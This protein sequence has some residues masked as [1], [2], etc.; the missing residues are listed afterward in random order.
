MGHCLQRRSGHCASPRRCRGEV[1]Q[2]GV[3][4]ATENAGA[5]V[6]SGVDDLLSNF[7]Q[8]VPIGLIALLEKEVDSGQT[9]DIGLLS[10]YITDLFNDS[11]SGVVDESTSYIADWLTA[12][13]GYEIDPILASL[14]AQASTVAA[15]PAPGQAS[16]LD[17]S[18]GELARPAL[19][20][21]QDLQAFG[22]WGPIVAAEKLVEFVPG[23]GITPYLIGLGGDI[24]GNIVD[25]NYLYDPIGVPDASA[26]LLDTLG[27]TWSSDESTLLQTAQT[28]QPAS[29]SLTS[30]ATADGCSLQAGV[31]TC[32]VGIVIG[33]SGTVTNASGSPLSGATVQITASDGA[34]TSASVT[35]NGSG[36]FT[37]GVL[38]PQNDGEQI[39]ITASAGGTAVATVPVQVGPGPVEDVELSGPGSL[40][41]G[42]NAPIS[43]LVT[44]GYGNPVPEAPINLSAS[45]GSVT[46]EATV[47]DASGTFE[48]TVTT[49]ATGPFI[50]VV[51]VSPDSL[52]S[53]KLTIAVEPA[54]SP[55][56]VHLDAPSVAGLTASLAGTDSPGSN[57]F[58]ITE[59]TW[60]WG[61]GT[62]TTGWFP[63]SHTYAAGGTYTITVTATDSDGQTGTASTTVT[64]NAPSSNASPLNI[65][66]TMLPTAE[67]NTPYAA[68][69]EVA[70]GTPPY[71]FAWSGSL[72]PGLYFWSPQTL[73]GTPT[74]GGVYSFKETVSDSSLPQQ[75]VTET[76]TAVVQPTTNLTITTPSVP[77][78]TVGTPYTA[79][80]DAVG[81]DPPYTW[82]SVAG[83]EPPSGLTL[84]ANGVLSGTPSD[85]GYVSFSAMVTDHD[86]TVAYGGFTMTVSTPTA[87]GSGAL[88]EQIAP[89]SA[90]GQLM[91]ISCV[92]DAQ[93]TDCFA[94][95]P[96][97]SGEGQILHS[98]DGGATWTSETAPAGVESSNGVLWGLDC[99]SATVCYAGDETQ[100]IKTTDGQN[101]ALVPLPAEYAYTQR[102]S[103]PSTTDC[104]MV[105]GYPFIN[106]QSTAVMQ[107]TDGGSTWTTTTT[108][109]FSES[110]I[111]CPTTAVCWVAG[112]TEHG[113]EDGGV[114]QTTDG[115]GSWSV[116]QSFPGALML[117]GITCTSDV[118]CWVTGTPSGPTRDAPFVAYTT[119]GTTWNTVGTPESGYIGGAVTGG[120]SCAS[121]LECLLFNSSAQD[122][123]GTTSG[124]ASPWTVYPTSGQ[125]EGVS[126]VPS[127]ECWLVSDSGAIFATSL[128]GS[129]TPASGATQL[130]ITSSPVAT[131]PTDSPTAG[132]ITITEE[133]SLG[134]PIDA[135]PGGTTVSLASSSSTA[136]F[137]AT[138]GGA[139]SAWT[140]IPAG[141]SSVTVFYGDAAAGPATITASSGG[142]AS[143]TQVETVL[144]PQVITIT[145]NPPARAEVG[146]TYT[147]TATG[148]PSGGSVTFSADSGSTPGACTVSDAGVVVFAAVGSCIIDAN[149]GG[150]NGYAPAQ[151][152][153]QAITVSPGPP[154]ITWTPPTPIVY[155][156]GLSSGQLDATTSVPG[157]LI[158]SPFV[159]TILTAGPQRLNVTFIPTNLSEYAPATSTVTLQVVP[160]PT[161]VDVEASPNPAT[162]GGAVAFVASGLPLD[163]TGSVSFGASGS[164]LCAATVA[165][166]SASCSA[167]D[168]MAG[169]HQVTAT[170]S[171]DANYQGSSQ[172]VN[173]VVAQAPTAVVASSSPSST[174]FGNA[175][176]LSATGLPADATGS[177]A[178][179]AAGATLCSADVAAGAAACPTATLPVA[180]YAVT[181]SYS[182]DNDFLGSTATTSFT[183]TSAPAAPVGTVTPTTPSA[184]S[185]KPSPSTTSKLSAT[186]EAQYVRLA[187]RTA[188]VRLTCNG[189][190]GQRCKIV[191]KL[192]AIEELTRG[193]VIAAVARIAR[194]SETSRRLLL[195]RTALTLMAKESRTVSF[196]LDKT[197]RQLL[198]RLGTLK[199]TLTVSQVR[200]GRQVAWT[201][202][203]TLRAKPAKRR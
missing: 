73:S 185:G 121:A 58:A 12:L 102:I 116:A 164:A 171:G 46:P 113:T 174:S 35:T 83:T 194:R 118:Q 85:A 98:T 50:D 40:A 167:T 64:V 129:L 54:A 97:V 38:L 55:P 107:T 62:T 100:L 177:V 7:V 52:V 11:F 91:A 95:G 92:P 147:A 63:Q 67:V 1:D 172:T 157:V 61:D 65:T 117:N 70:G 41:G 39:T 176:K 108:P 29:L 152:A 9:L 166:G 190:A 135:P 154:A 140:T 145:S 123:Y 51:A 93:Q 42:S 45:S 160:A 31:P 89:G 114:L 59:L 141:A 143:A 22:D 15:S 162:Y 189:S 179:T 139:P 28:T 82:A 156:T 142:L 69:I 168:I 150:G 2:I 6:E 124:G 151:Q 57:G 19:W 193:K 186:I 125:S 195:A 76:I 68:S 199:V 103:C 201:K 86:G 120:V 137:S 17:L 43:G 104:Y 146:G 178:F 34:P 56:V 183:I 191:A 203:L 136:A 144:D 80:L 155:G 47:A 99:P 88:V 132:P 128:D 78:A 122:A 169:S 33:V 87:G 149:Q 188:S 74:E 75:T 119:D 110:G 187:G 161:T 53:G 36:A 44:D 115:G 112:Q 79:T 60:Q 26:G 3:A 30:D 16:A 134:D 163:A 200:S 94:V 173:I 202:A 84:S 81:G 181:A 148:G 126:C 138:S 197:G 66:N 14:V 170:Y 109:N 21:Y 101:W 48:A 96:G 23:I 196:A 8:N 180:S 153:Q 131:P 32:E 90:V 72:P 10:D 25:Q 49:P 24:G 37:G 175:V 27:A 192:T 77:N 184:S 182:G 127:G 13:N 4:F 198:A 5:L 71:T 105:A 133:D 158:Y 20:T 106:S 130:A 165:G 159:G 111:S 18:M